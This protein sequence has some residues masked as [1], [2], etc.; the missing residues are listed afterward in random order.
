[1]NQFLHMCVQG[2]RVFLESKQGIKTDVIKFGSF[3]N[4]WRKF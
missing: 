3:L 4:I 1:M 2:P